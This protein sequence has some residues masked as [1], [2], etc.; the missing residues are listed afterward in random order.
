[1]DTL[2]GSDQAR[3]KKDGFLAI[4]DLYLP[5]DRIYIIFSGDRIVYYMDLK[6]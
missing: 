5:D 4:V 6:V 2:E 1:M 3:N